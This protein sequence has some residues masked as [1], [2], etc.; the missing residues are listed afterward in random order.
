M[1]QEIQL[2]VVHAESELESA[3]HAIDD[4]VRMGRSTDDARARYRAALTDFRQMAKVQH[5]LDLDLL[6]DLELRVASATGLVHAQ[7][8]VAA[9]QQWEHKLLL[10]PIW[11]FVLAG[12]ALAAFRLREVR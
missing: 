1:G 2:H 10:L 4:L 7:A 9:E 11:F 3:A 6:E 12:M 5:S 8:E